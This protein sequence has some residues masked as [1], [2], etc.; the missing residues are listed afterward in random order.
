MTTVYDVPPEQLIKKVAEKLKENENIQPP[1]WAPYVKTGAHREKPPEDSDWWYTRVA[2]VLRK[3]YIKGPIGIEHLR[4]EFGGKRDRGSKRYHPVK[5]SGSIVR[6]A[7]QQLEAA[8]YVKKNGTRGRVI[9]PEGQRLLDNTA[10]EVKL[11]IIKDI[12]ELGKY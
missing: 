11:E 6:K 1:E 2:A 4:A 10:H 12:P 3:V 9:T 7:L 5:G 8:G